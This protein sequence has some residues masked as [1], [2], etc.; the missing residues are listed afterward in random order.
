MKA[1]RLCDDVEIVKFSRISSS[2]E[3]PC[4]VSVDPGCNFG[5]HKRMTIIKHRLVSVSSLDP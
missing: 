1:W 4:F 5:Y 3:V 2:L